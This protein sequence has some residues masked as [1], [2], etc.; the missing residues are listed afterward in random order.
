ML[1]GELPGRYKPIF[2]FILVFEDV[3]HHNFMMC[4]VGWVAMFLKFLLQVVFYLKGVE[5]K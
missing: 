3:I 2:I 5:R 1:V 4:V